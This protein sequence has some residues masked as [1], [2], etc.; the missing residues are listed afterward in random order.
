MSEDVSA[1]LESLLGE[2]NDR[3]TLKDTLG[4]MDDQHF[5]EVVKVVQSEYDKRVP[6][7][8]ANM[9]DGQFNAYVNAVTKQP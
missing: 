4:K 9:T 8:V 1:E 6:V 7:D 5:A 3:P 2:V